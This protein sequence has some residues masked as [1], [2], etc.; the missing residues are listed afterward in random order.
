M[1]VVMSL[2]ERVLVLDFGRTIAVGTPAEV[3]ASPEVIRA[4]LGEPD[5]RGG[6]MKT[7]ALLLFSGLALGAI[8]ALIALG[9]T[10]IY[11]AS[12]IINFAQ[13]ELLALG[14][15]VTSALIS[16]DGLPFWLAFIIGAVATG[17]AG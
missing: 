1:S 4:Y 7:F 10:V 17:A 13:G 15:C 12:R 8:Y 6:C 3:Q 16:A 14:A 2:A 11:R 5:P 9:F